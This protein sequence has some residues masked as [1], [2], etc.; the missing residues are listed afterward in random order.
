M[1]LTII[2]RSSSRPRFDRRRLRRVLET[3]LVEARCRPE[4]CALTVL[5]VDDAESARLHD[6]HFSIPEATDVMTF[7]DGGMDPDL[8]R[9]HLGDLA[10]GVGVAR[11]EAKARGRSPGDEL[12]L[13]ILHGLL[14]LLGHDD[15]TVARRKRMWSAQRRLLATI[16]IKL[17]ASPG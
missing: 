8:G 3:A 10:V 5:L 9:Q 16:G 7:P 11:R 2:D 15:V 12:I 6:Q 13:Y 14:H 4:F 1:L 17:E